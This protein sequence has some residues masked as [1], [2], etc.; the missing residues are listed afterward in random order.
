MKQCPN[1]GAKLLDEARFCIHCITILTKKTVLKPIKIIGR[2]QRNSAI[3]FLVCI[4]FT[5]AIF[6]TVFLYKNYALE[7]R[8]APSRQF[9]VR[10]LQK[11][12]PPQQTRAMKTSEMRR[13]LIFQPIHIQIKT[14]DPMIFILTRTRERMIFIPTRTPELTTFFINQ[15]RNRTIF[16]PNQT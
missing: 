12:N 7:D 13:I 5:A 2:W 16:I 4:S 3:A 8:N 15:I 1:C 14:R 9:P 10:I 11:T 6:S